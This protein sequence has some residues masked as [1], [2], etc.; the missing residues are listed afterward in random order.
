MAI[1]CPCNK[2]K[3]TYNSSRINMET[4]VW[5]RA[6]PS[7]LVW[8]PFPAVISVIHYQHLLSLPQDSLRI[9]NLYIDKAIEASARNRSRYL[10]NIYIG[11]TFHSRQAQVALKYFLWNKYSKANKS[12]KE[13]H[14]FTKLEGMSRLEYWIGI[15]QTV[16][17]VCN[18]ATEALGCCI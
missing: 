14:I 1:W 18:R 9:I 15:L 7:H 12:I 2:K 16:W 10:R 3:N 6:I 8:S 5:W 13:S 17:L 11:Y 4:S